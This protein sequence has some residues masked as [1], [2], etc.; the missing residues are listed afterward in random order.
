MPHVPQ[1]MPLPTRP[2][3]SSAT[4]GLATLA[5]LAVTASALAQD[6]AHPLEAAL[7][8]QLR[9]A[10]FRAS[11]RCMET[12]TALFHA[13]AAGFVDVDADGRGEFATL[14]ELLGLEKWRGRDEDPAGV[15]TWPGASVVAPGVVEADGYLYRVELK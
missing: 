4:V 8:R 2:S 13:Q 15:M 9:T 1:T 3:R 7:T 5:L 10:Q 11:G 6:A 12:R 14:P